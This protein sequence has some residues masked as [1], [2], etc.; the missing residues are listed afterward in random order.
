MLQQS[1]ISLVMVTRTVLRVFLG[2]AAYPAFYVRS[3]LPKS[4]G[5]TRWERFKSRV[6]DSLIPKLPAWAEYHGGYII[7]AKTTYGKATVDRF[8]DRVPKRLLEVWQR[9]SVAMMF[10]LL[11]LWSL[12]LL[13]CLGVLLGVSA[14]GLYS[15][16]QNPPSFE[17]LF[18]EP[19]LGETDVALTLGDVLYY[20]LH[21]VGFLIVLFVV[22][23]ATFLLFLPGMMLHEGGH[24][25]AARR[26]DLTV[27]YYGIIF[28]GPLPAGAFV[29]IPDDELEEAPRE[30]VLPTLAGGIGNTMLWASAL[31][32]TGG[33]VLLA[34]TQFDLSSLSVLGYGLVLIGGF[35]LFNAY[36]NAF[37]AGK[38]DGGLFVEAAQDKAD[39]KDV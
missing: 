9:F 39:C 12:F 19:S 17:W 8:V 30:N 33:S 25:L 31:L 14:T 24:Y 7:M 32:V 37:P 3:Y 34:A 18:V 6:G 38:V 26:N 28:K 1:V 4:D 20:S 36:I 22:F 13:A 10:V 15:L 27:D 23:V 21:F 35:E 2:G 29:H 5:P 16:L 11:T